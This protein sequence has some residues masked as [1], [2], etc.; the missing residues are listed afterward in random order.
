MLFVS[1]DSTI[2]AKTNL[3]K[4]KSFFTTEES[5]QALTDQIITEL[6]SDKLTSVDH[7]VQLPTQSLTVTKMCCAV[8]LLTAFNQQRL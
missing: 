8:K 2:N 7:L 1:S 6:Q 5:S 3:N 4:D